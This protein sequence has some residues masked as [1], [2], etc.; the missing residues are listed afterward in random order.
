MGIFLKRRTFMQLEL[1]EQDIKQ[2]EQTL[3]NLECSLVYLRQEE[4]KNVEIIS[5]LS[6]EVFYVKDQLGNYRIL[7]DLLKEERLSNDE[8]PQKV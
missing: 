4:A 2:R 7:V 5:L 1:V 6:H 3:R 8:V